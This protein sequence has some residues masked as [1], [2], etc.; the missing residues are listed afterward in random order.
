M[1]VCICWYKLFNISANYVTKISDRK[2]TKPA[3][4]YMVMRGGAD[5]RGN[6]NVCGGDNRSITRQLCRY[7]G[8]VYD[9]SLL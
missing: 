2:K 1:S 3:L 4:C 7:S 6:G 5:G 9:Q 8:N